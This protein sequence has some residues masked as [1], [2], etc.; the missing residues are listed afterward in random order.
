MA[1][2]SGNDDATVEKDTDYSPASGAETEAAQ[3]APRG[4]DHLDDPEI[5]GGRV[6]SVPGVGGPDDAGD[7]DVD[8]EAIRGEIAE[9]N[10][11]RRS[12]G[13]PAAGA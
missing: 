10:E 6:N 12:A 7:V 11:E 13:L 8:D 1:A 4:T 9:H 3:R 2:L 5:D